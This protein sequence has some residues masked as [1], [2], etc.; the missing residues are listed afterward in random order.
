MDD[1]S[2]ESDQASDAG[3]TKVFDEFDCPVCN[4]NNP[5]GDGFKVGDEIRC[6]YCGTEYKVKVTDTGKLKLKEM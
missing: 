1:F 6:F 3:K 5:Y 4:A 2:D